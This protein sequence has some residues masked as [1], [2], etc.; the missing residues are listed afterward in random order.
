MEITWHHGGL[1]G[2]NEHDRVTHEAGDEKAIENV[3]GT[4]YPAVVDK[5][6]RFWAN[7]LSESVEEVR[8]RLKLRTRE[9]RSDDCHMIST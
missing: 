4:R 1:Y 7:W 9:T 8:L 5:R 6:K 3:T 2:R